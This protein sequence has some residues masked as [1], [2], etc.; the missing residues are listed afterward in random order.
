MMFGPLKPIPQLTSIF[1]SFDL[2]F[3]SHHASLYIPQ[4]RGIC[5]SMSVFF[6][7]MQSAVNPYCG[8]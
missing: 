3:F 8:K 6:H 2:P 4:I 7:L 5:L 1:V